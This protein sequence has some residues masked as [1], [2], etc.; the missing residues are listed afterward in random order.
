MSQHFILQAYDKTL[1][2]N[3]SES[4]L[5]TGKPLSSK[6]TWRLLSFRL[7]EAFLFLQHILALLAFCYIYE[8]ERIYVTSKISQ[9]LHNKMMARVLPCSQST[10]T[11]PEIHSWQTML[12]MPVASLFNIWER[13]SLCHN[14]FYISFHMASYSSLSTILI[15]HFIGRNARRLFLYIIS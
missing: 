7:L 14:I 13:M 5:G 4:F 2:N 12:Q 3:T 10:I 9:T 6:D 8:K 15:Y 1:G 11:Q